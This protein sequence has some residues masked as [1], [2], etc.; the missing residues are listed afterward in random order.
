M[1]TVKQA[2]LTSVLHPFEA[3]VFFNATA[4]ASNQQGAINLARRC[5]SATSTPKQTV[6]LLMS[7]GLGFKGEWMSCAACAPSMSINVGN[8]LAL[9]GQLLSQRAGFSSHRHC[10]KCARLRSFVSRLLAVRA[11]VRPW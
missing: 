1:I 7:C 2:E 4:A 9:P 5:A 8:C 6:E 11:E 3:C 10:T